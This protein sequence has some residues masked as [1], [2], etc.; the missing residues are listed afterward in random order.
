MW[1]STA[2]N[3]IWLWLGR[4]A[5]IWSVSIE[6]IEGEKNIVET[7]EYDSSNKIHLFEFKRKWGYCLHI[8]PQPYERGI[9]FGP[10]LVFCDP[11]PHRHAALVAAVNFLAEC[12]RRSKKTETKKV[13]EWAK[14]LITPKQLRLI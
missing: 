4:R 9:F 12:Y 11:H 10:L 14:S 8:W 5:D 7:V 2:I 1:Q 13:L 3:M 6:D